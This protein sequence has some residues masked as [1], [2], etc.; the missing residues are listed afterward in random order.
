MDASKVAKLAVWTADKMVVWTVTSKAVSSVGTMVYAT[1]AKLGEA[2]VV[3]SASL[4]GLW[5]VDKMGVFLGERWV[6]LSASDL[7]EMR[8]DGLVFPTVEA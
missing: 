1:A 4:W 6:D 5:T 2:K 8:V 7:V 3:S